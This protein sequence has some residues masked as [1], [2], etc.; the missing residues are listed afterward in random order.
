M[1]STDSQ[2]FNPPPISAPSSKNFSTIQG[3]AVVR[4]NNITNDSVSVKSNSNVSFNIRNP[5]PIQTSET[6]KSPL[7]KVITLSSPSK[8]Y[9]KNVTSNC[10]ADSALGNSKVPVEEMAIRVVV[11]KRP[12]SRAEMARGDR[13]VMEIQT[14]GIVLVHEPKVKVDLTKVIETQEFIFDDSFDIDENNEQIYNRTVKHLV[15]FVFEGGKASCFAYG[16]TGS[17]KTF[18]MM[19]ETPD[20]PVEACV[21]SGLYVLAARDIFQ[22]LNTPEYGHLQVFISCFEIYGGKLF[23]L[24][25]D[26][27]IVKCLEDAKQQVQLPGLTE[28]IVD[29]VSTL[30]NL[31]GKA[32]TQRSTGSTGANE[33]SSRS[34][35]IMQLVLREP[36][37][38]NHISAIGGKLS[39][40][41]L[42]GSERGADTNHSSKQTRME[43][44]EINTSLLALKEVIRSLERKHGHTPFRGSKLTQV[45]KD[46]FIGEKTRTCMIACV[47]PSNSNCEHTLN[48]LRYADRVK[49]HQASQQT[50][51]TP[52]RNQLNI[53]T[54][55]PI[56]VQLQQD[57]V[58]PRPTTSSSAT[59]ING[60]KSIRSIHRPLTS[61]P[62]LASNVPK[63]A[64]SVLQKREL[65]QKG[66]SASP[67]RP[68]IR[69]NNLISEPSPLIVSPIS[70]MR[71][72]IEAI[73]SNINLDKLGNTALIQ[74]TVEL[75]SSHRLS[76]AEMVEVMKDE[77]ALVQN[78]E[79]AEDRNVELYIDRLEQILD[80][81]NDAI[82]SLKMRLF[83]Y[84]QFR[85]KF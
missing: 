76:I 24:L 48:T 41:D 38:K 49:E 26:R 61:E 83:A 51:A 50:G 85:Q 19:G 84:T 79:N 1:K 23:D 30:L 81:K 29:N 65:Q 57:S 36:K 15:S 56:H 70:P 71:K 4:G 55:Q 73:D 21:N 6:F 34:H 16:Q 59:C 25:N 3:P 68:G 39:F 58:L 35:Q 62:K 69:K 46:S 12:L 53:V 75:L 10:V 13:D 64:S 52:P 40:I 14:C 7:I 20:I 9:K 18:T 54:A 42:A 43:G 63:I 11:R 45:L 44:A 74:E 8:D 27:G 22:S 5:S 47:S 72:S 67:S 17:G 80:K 82:D 78:M 37:R 32:H 33:T 2:D 77:M 60:H 66:I 28:H 31:M